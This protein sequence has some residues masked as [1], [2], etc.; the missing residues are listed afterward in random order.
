MPA[1]RQPGHR[2]GPV[3]IQLRLSI[4]G[5]CEG[6]RV[7]DRFA[8][9]QSCEILDRVVAA[10]DITDVYERVVADRSE[11]AVSDRPRAFEAELVDLESQ[12]ERLIDAVAAGAIAQEPAR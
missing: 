4:H 10:I 6:F 7:L 12:E 3:G 11:A 5:L 8:E 1:L 2:S 9:Q